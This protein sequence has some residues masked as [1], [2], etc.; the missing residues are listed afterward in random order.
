M[1]SPAPGG[2]TVSASNI[3]GLIPHVR[4]PFNDSMALCSY[5]EGE[6]SHS[7]LISFCKMSRM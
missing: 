6:A 7:C 5:F 2:Q 3:S 1:D 4:V